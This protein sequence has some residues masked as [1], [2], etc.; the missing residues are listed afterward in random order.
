VDS[1]SKPNALANE[2]N[3]IG[4]CLFDHEEI[5]SE[6]SHGAASPI[7]NELI[8]R[9]TQNVLLEPVAIR[10]SF[11]ISADMA[12]AVH[13]N[14]REKHDPN[15]KPAIHGGVVI[16]HNGNQR[17]ATNSITAF[18]I[19]EISKKYNVPIQEFVVRNDTLCGSTIGPIVSTNTGIRTVDIGN[20]QWSMHSIRETCGV[21]DLTHCVNLLKGFFAEFTA[22]DGQLVVD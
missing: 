8:R 10:R 16:K 20:P 15:H 21:A 13:P 12:H 22:L 3:V 14:Y 6:S 19:R 17:Y 5:G 2:C 11:F 4:I 18:P 9:V 1:L 7:V